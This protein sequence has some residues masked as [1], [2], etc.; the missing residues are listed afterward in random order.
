MTYADWTYYAE[1]FGGTLQAGEIAPHLERASDDIDALTFSRIHAIGWDRLTA[2]QRE[3]VQ[4]ACC[5]QAQFLAENADAVDSSISR[6]A[7]N[8]VS[9]EF[10]NSAL[11][12]VVQ[13]VPVANAALSLLRQTGLTCLLAAPA[14]VGHALA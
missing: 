3:R 9:I 13:G 5:A 7:I 10:G 6:Y 8:G 12:Q 2:F 4:R 1:E 11:Y 14:E